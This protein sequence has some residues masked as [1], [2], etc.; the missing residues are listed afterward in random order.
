MEDLFLFFLFIL[1]LCV[2]SFLNVVIQRL[3]RGSSII[4][5]R[6]HC[7]SCKKNLKWYDMVPL[8]SFVFLKGKCRFCHSPISWQYPTVEL[9]TGILFVATILFLPE[10]SIM[11]H[12]VSIKYA[13]PIVYFLFIVS[14]FIAIFFIDLKHGIIPD[15]I[16]YPAVI[17]S[18]LY[19]ILNTYYPLRSEASLIL[20]YFLSAV[21]A[22]LFFLLIFLATRGRGMGFGD[23]KLSFLMGLVLGFPAIVIALY[24]AF[25]T[26][27][28]ASIILVVLG[29]KKIPGG[30]IPF[31]PFLV[32]GTFIALF[33][34]RYIQE[35][36]RPF[37]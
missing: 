28:I 18:L 13:I 35:I 10:K 25:L 24:S 27:A 37:F 31:G 4:K 12:V 9:I 2:G 7:F 8:L 20:P 26:G 33:F 15:K 3:P 22:F 14:S 6:S 17:I 16:V 5:K 32:I 30:T 21:G 1:G 23:V 11:Y 29:K 36:I 19:I 34:G